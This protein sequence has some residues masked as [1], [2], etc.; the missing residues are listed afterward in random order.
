MPAF[1]S[2]LWKLEAI[3]MESDKQGP[4][5]EETSAADKLCNDHF[6]KTTKLINNVFTVSLPLKKKLFF[7]RTITLKHYS[8]CTAVKELFHETEKQLW[9]NITQ[10]WIFILVG[11]TLKL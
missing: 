8:A 10:E 3:G 6:N 5:S 2:N 1:V 7:S 4:M 9:M 11:A